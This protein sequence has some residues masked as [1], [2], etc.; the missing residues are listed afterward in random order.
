[1][2]RR[3]RGHTRKRGRVKRTF[4]NF[5]PVSKEVKSWSRLSD[6]LTFIQSFPIGSLNFVVGPR[7]WTGLDQ[8]QVLICLLFLV[9][10]RRRGED[11]CPSPSHIWH[12]DIQEQ[13]TV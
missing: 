12:L 2:V 9:D 13:P 1:M 3:E 8:T 4:C 5:T 6:C 11:V 10:F 7:I